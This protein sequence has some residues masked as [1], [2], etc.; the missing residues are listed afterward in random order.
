MHAVLLSSS[1]TCFYNVCID[2]HLHFYFYT[3]H[4]DDD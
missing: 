4:N 2:L 1:L 3:H